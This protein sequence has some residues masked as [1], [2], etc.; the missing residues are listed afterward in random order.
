MNLDENYLDL[1]NAIVIQA[2]EDYTEALRTIRISKSKTK[3]EKA[4]K[5]KNKCEKF[6]RTE[7]FFELSRFAIDYDALIET[8]HKNAQKD[9]EKE[10][11]KKRK[12][13]KKNESKAD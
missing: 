10:K 13:K 4:E 6:F 1:A 8:C 3:L 12:R 9:K 11:D 7:W 2:V 5:V